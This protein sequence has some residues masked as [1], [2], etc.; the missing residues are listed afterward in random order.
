MGTLFFKSP[1]GDGTTIIFMWSSEPRE[2]ICRAKAVLS[3]LSHVNTL[4]VG[5]V[6]GIEPATSRSAVLKALL[7][8]ELILC[9]ALVIQFILFQREVQCEFGEMDQK[10]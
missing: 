2:A 10:R 6:P 7:P 4:S 8:T 3:F 9:C 1:A 5:L